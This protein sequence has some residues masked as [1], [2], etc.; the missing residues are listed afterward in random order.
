MH[1]NKAAEG[2]GSFCGRVIT[3]TNTFA[4][5]FARAAQR[6]FLRTSY[7]EEDFFSAREDAL[8]GV[9]HRVLLSNLRTLCGLFSLRRPA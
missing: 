4:G 6:C 3:G 9:F 5:D 8:A 1:S 7:K 2:H